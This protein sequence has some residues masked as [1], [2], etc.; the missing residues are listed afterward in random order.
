MS[1]PDRF[2]M[3]DAVRVRTGMR[4]MSRHYSHGDFVDTRELFAERRDGAIFFEEILRRDLVTER[5]DVAGWSLTASGHEIASRPIAPPASRLRAERAL[6]GLLGDID[7]I[8][9][10]PLS[11]DTVDEVWISGA[12]LT[13]A[14]EMDAVELHILTSRRP[15]F[16][17]AAMALS[18][19]LDSL[20]A[21]RV[22]R[23]R[24]M[25][26]ADLPNWL[27]EAML[28]GKSSR[29]AIFSRVQMTLDDLIASSKPCA[30]LF[31]REGGVR[32]EP[33]RQHHP[34]S[35]GYR[36]PQME[37]RGLMPMDGTW[38]S[39]Y[40]N[41]GRISPYFLFRGFDEA[42]RQLFPSEGTLRVACGG[43]PADPSIWTPEA[44]SKL[45]SDGRSQV[46][47]ML[48]NGP[49]R[50]LGVIA[51]RRLVEAD[52][53]F[54]V[55][56]AVAATFD[57]AGTEGAPGIHCLP[58]GH[59]LA[60]LGAADLE[61]AMRDRFD[62]DDPG[63]FGLKIAARSDSEA[64]AVIAGS[65]AQSIQTGRIR[66]AP[67]GWTGSAAQVEC[68]LGGVLR[69]KTAM[70]MPAAASSGQQGMGVD[71]DADWLSESASL[72]FA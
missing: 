13:P 16:E 57:D 42:A 6:K 50:R 18:H 52:D 15:G 53:S 1:V 7:A 39:A 34:Q 27:V 19:T 22:R 4:Q 17:D 32:M 41:W 2:A 26:D 25:A 69:A 56:I 70:A 5:D 68:E 10:S 21:L 44:V 14:A 67:S 55:E 35:Q 43:S 23:P 24:G 64:A 49:G 46:A 66:V 58:L 12:Y 36:Q 3:F 33:S 65:A 63:R 11:M 48:D 40:A 72:D 61:R 20:S 54:E 8:N 60:L 71:E 29:P 9:M 28:F 47:V 38:L 62:R 59:C 31:T 37:V 45:S 51:E 30:R